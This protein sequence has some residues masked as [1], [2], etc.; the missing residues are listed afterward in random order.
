MERLSGKKNTYK[1]ALIIQN[2][3]KVINLFHKFF[4]EKLIA[5]FPTIN[6]TPLIAKPIIRPIVMPRKQN[7]GQSA[8]NNNK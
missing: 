4:F 3:K 2:L 6:T 5:I 1:L 8:N 7:H